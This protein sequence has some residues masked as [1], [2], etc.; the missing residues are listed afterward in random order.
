M[1]V[2]RL[3]TKTREALA[4]SQQIAA[5]MGSPELYPEHVLLA[6]YGRGPLRLSSRYGIFINMGW[7]EGYAE[8]FAPKGT[9]EPTKGVGGGKLPS[10][11]ERDFHALM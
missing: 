2:D 6:P 9:A 4:A 8:A 11:L 10:K 5:E 1:R 7:V 3:T